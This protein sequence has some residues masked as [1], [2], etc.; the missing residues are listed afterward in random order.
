[1][2]GP[3]QPNQPLDDQLVSGLLLPRNFVFGAVP[4]GFATTGIRSRALIAELPP[5]APPLGPLESFTDPVADQ[6]ITF[7]GNGFN[8]IFRPHSSTAPTDPP[9]NVGDNVLE[10]NLTTETLSFQK[11]LGTVPNRGM[12]Q[13]DTFLNG[14]PYLQTIS[15]VTQPGAPIGIHVEPGIWMF[16]QETSH[17][18]LTATLMRMASIPHGTTILAQGTSTSAKGA[19][20]IP[21]V[22]ITPTNPAGKA[23]TF[24]SQDAT[25]PSDARIPPDLAPYIAA[26]TI[27]P[28]ILKDPNTVLRNHIKPQKIISTITIT[29]STDP[30]QPLF[31]GGADNMAFLLGDAKAANPNA[32]AIRM[33]AT[34]WIETVQHTVVVPPVWPGSLLLHPEGTLAPGQ[35]APSFLVNP[36]ATISEPR[37]ISV[38]STQIQYSQQVF[39]NFNGLTWPHV[40]VATLVPRDPIPV[41]WT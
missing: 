16:V 20:K 26:G 35:P 2:T 25:K 38:Q 1:M 22:D 39:L 31:G 33:E 19:P 5:Q 11:S 27:T 7:S 28:A 24:D 4:S 34:F 32:Q 15:D 37:T 10:L 3:E 12:L 29:I 40:S 21:T 30:A 13:G 36:P 23:V 6:G 8:T 18:A 17:P 41:P 9:A 14:V